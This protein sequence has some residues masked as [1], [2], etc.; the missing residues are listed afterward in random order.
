M[1]W[2]SKRFVEDAQEFHILSVLENFSQVQI[3]G[4]LQGRY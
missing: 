1:E 2:I 4:G 3:G